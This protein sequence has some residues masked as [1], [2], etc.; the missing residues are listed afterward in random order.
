MTAS[1][2]TRILLPCDSP[3][4]QYGVQ[5]QLNLLQGLESL[6]RL[7]ANTAKGTLFPY[8]L[9]SCELQYTHELSVT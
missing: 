1:F 7:S 4:G 8:K 2:C 9:L 6:F 5:K 3:L